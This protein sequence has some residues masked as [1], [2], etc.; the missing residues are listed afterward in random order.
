MLYL[1]EI[2]GNSKGFTIKRELKKVKEELNRLESIIDVFYEGIITGEIIPG[3]KFHDSLIQTPVTEL[4]VPIIE[5]L[6][7]D[8]YVVDE[9]LDGENIK[10][11]E[12][13]VFFYATSVGLAQFFDQR[14]AELGNNLN[15]SYEGALDCINATLQYLYPNPNDFVYEYNEFQK[16]HY[17]STFEEEINSFTFWTDHLLSHALQL[18]YLGRLQAID[19]LLKK[20]LKEGASFMD[21]REIQLEAEKCLKYFKT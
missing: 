6:V 13:A 15:L 5:E 18:D 7:Q 11:S 14:V 3:T 17:T 20:S 16:L 10:E 19:D 4:Y 21:L 2:N 8:F 12:H 9:Y 1:R